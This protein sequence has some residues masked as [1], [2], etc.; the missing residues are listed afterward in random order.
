M[1]R[2]RKERW[3]IVLIILILIALMVGG[4]YWFIST[5][6][7]KTVYVEG[8]VH[9]TTEEIKEIVMEGPLG[10]N[11]VYL[12]MK[13]RNKGVE[14]IPFVDVMDVAV[15][16]PDTIKI[17]V[18]EKAL[19]GYV[20]FMDSFMYF[21]RDG[22]MV[23]T[24]NVRTVG[25]PQIAGL[26]FEHVVLGE[27]IPVQKEDIFET[28]MSITNLLEK[29][30]LMVDKIYFQ[31]DMDIVLYFGDLRVFMGKGE[32]LEEKIISLTSIMGHLEGASGVLH[33]ENY[34]DGG[35]LTIF[36]MDETEEN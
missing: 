6:S 34:S 4:F 7:V 27:K 26:Q 24:S 29:F 25:V 16:A 13:Y 12:S 19:A 10:S 2:R 8:N 33:L 11:S 30:E 20:E 36:E 22:Y 9:Y 5:Y 31:T 14:N 35:D 1:Y 21:D 23:E 3:G 18:Y 28:V 32:N 15:L 17:V